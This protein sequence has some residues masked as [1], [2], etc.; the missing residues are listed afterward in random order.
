[1]KILGKRIL[2]SNLRFTFEVDGDE[3]SKADAM[4][5]K[6]LNEAVCDTPHNGNGTSLMDLIVLLT[7]LVDSNG[8]IK[9]A[10]EPIDDE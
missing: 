7:P 2:N 1:M 9:V 4:R 5:M 3:V 10:I 6:K 8:E